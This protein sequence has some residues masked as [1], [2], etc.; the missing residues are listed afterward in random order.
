MSRSQSPNKLTEMISTAN[1]APG[2]AVI[3]HSPEKR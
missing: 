2:K 3:H 1:M